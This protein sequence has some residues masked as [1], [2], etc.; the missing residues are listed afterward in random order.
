MSRSTASWW[1]GLLFV[2][3]VGS[4]EAQLVAVDDGYGV[5]YGEPLVVEAPGVLSNDTYNGDPAEDAGATVEL[6]AGVSHGT[7]SCDSD[8]SF[9]L[10]PDG[11]F[12]YTPDS[13]LGGTD[14]FTYEATVGTETSQATATLTACTGGPSVFTCWQEAS[15]LAK[16]GEL[17]YG[18]FQEGFE[19]DVAWGGVRS[20]DTAPSV[21]SQ[22]VTWQ[23]NHPDPPASN[24]IT[25]GMGPARTGEWGVY[26][27]NHGYATGT[28]AECD[29]NDPPSHCLY[30]DGFT[31]IREA[32]ESPL[33]GV[34]GYFT[35]AAQ[36][37]LVLYLDGAIPPISLGNLFVGGHQFFGVIDTA[38]FTTFRVEETDGK[39]GQQ[40][41][42][43]ADDFTF[44]V[45]ISVVFADGFES[46]DTSAWT[47]TLPQTP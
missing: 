11:S 38:G 42:V 29:V 32:G 19:D 31:G 37:N 1:V 14:S 9:E 21:L 23:T 39:V 13:F 16:L 26:D 10:C 35:G 18:N 4:A 41:F 22:G 6:L 20:P 33:Y 12:I 28:P 3:L 17:G 45:P 24:E 8:P 2:G 43:F 5:P 25:T 40:R 7:L 30:H 44:A 34:G 47:I 46:G 15:Y 36:P 27:P